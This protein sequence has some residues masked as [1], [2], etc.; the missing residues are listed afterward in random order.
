[1]KKYYNIYDDGECKICGSYGKT[2][3]SSYDNVPRCENCFTTF[4]IEL[5]GS[6]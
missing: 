5:A 6:E 3:T 1:M 2:I 4:L